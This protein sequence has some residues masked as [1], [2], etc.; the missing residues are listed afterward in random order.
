MRTRMGAPAFL[1][2]CVPLLSKEDDAADIGRLHPI[3]SRLL[4]E[5]GER[6]D[7]QLAFASNLHTYGWSGS[8]ATHYSAYRE[9]FEQLRSHRNPQVRQWAEKLGREVDR[10]ITNETT[11]ARER[12][13]MSSWL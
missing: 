11:R 7:V 9:P 5:F 1:A 6:E 10:S 13:A 8:S 12:R 2:Q 4:D 3:M